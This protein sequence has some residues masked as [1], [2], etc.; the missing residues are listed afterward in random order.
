LVKSGDSIHHVLD[1][2]I[3][4]VKEGTVVAITSKIISL[5]QNR[6]VSKNHANSKY[7]LIQNEADAYLAEDQSL[8]NVH[9][10]IKN[11]ILIPSAGIDE[12]NGGGM[13]ILYPENIQQTALNIWEHLRNQ[14]HVKK[15]GIIITDSHVTPLRQGVVGIALGWCGFEPLYSYVGEPD[16]FNQP[17]RVTQINLLDALATSAVLMMGE[18]AEQ[19]PIALIKDAPKIKFL[20]RPPTPEEEQNI[21]IFVDKD[22]YYPLFKHTQWI[23]NKKT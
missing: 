7:E 5:C 2:Y 4:S 11:N 22:I 18:G 1:E 19:T 21:H 8:Y 20:D 13:Y 14:H 12:S 6:V 15:L 16:I 10:T 3:K 17:L 9:L 23:W